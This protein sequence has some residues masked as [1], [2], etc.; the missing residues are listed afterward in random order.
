MTQAPDMIASESVVALP[1]HHIDAFDTVAPT[2]R[3][4]TSC[5]LGDVAVPS[6]AIMHFPVALGGFPDEHEFVLL[7][8]PREGMWLLQST[9]EPGLIFVLGDP[10][11][12]DDSFAID[13]SVT[14]KASLGLERE[15][16][17]LALVMF[18]LSPTGSA[19]CTANFR[20]P[21]V[22]NVRNQLGVQVVNR[23]DRHELQRTVSLE[24]YPL[25]VNS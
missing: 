6:A 1:L 11:V 22:F 2:F 18:V 7:P 24:T 14:D 3:T 21:L 17:A 12:L 4:I 19:E 16:D 25:S 5:A 20:A 9:S 13:L 23:D 15:E 10:F 8:A